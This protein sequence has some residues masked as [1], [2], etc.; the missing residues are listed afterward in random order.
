MGTT[1]ARRF[2]LETQAWRGHGFSTPDQ[3]ERADNSISIVETP[4]S[5]EV[6]TVTCRVDGTFRLRLPVKGSYDTGTITTDLHRGSLAGDV[7]RAL[8]G[9][10][11][12]SQGSVSVRLLSPGKWRVHFKDPDAIAGE[13]LRASNVFPQ[14]LGE[15]VRTSENGIG[16][17]KAPRFSSRG[18]R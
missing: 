4:Q 12:V 1:N 17:S 9:L 10:D 7:V 14:L 13:D 3:W 16:P 8:E 11:A 5:D 6:Q 15:S 2:S 18:R